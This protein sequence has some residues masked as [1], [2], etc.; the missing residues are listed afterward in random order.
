MHNAWYKSNALYAAQ[1][2]REP[3]HYSLPLEH[4]G[5][6]CQVKGNN[7]LPRQGQDQ[8]DLMSHELSLSISQMADEIRSNVN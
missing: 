8:S 3:V 7:G 2:D 6:E 1:A 5:F 4:N